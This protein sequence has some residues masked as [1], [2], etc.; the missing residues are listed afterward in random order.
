M[1]PGLMTL[2]QWHDQAA[3]AFQQGRPQEAERICGLILQA[4]PED[5]LGHYLLGLVR[6]GQS[7]FDEALIHLDR[8][9]AARPHDPTL[10]FNRGNNFF[11]LGRI[12]EALAD[13]DR[14]VALAPGF[15]LAWNNRGN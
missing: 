13:Y 1:G 8:A 4:A 5:F 2:Q 10:L 6:H 11:A 3:T 15:P 14:S 7:R 9:V 12:A